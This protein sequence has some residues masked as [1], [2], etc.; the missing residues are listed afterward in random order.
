MPKLKENRMSVD[1]C[2]MVKSAS[3]SEDARKTRKEFE[4][5]I[6]S[7][8]WDNVFS[9]LDQNPDLINAPFLDDPL[10]Y[11]P[12]HHLTEENAPVEI[13]EKTIS[14]GAWRTLKTLNNEKPMD[15]ALRK[16]RQELISLL[17]PIYCHSL[18]LESLSKIQKHFHEVIIGRISGL[19]NWNS[20]RL[21]ELEVL[22]EIKD[23]NMWFAV[24]GMYGGFNYWLAYNR[25][26]T[27]RLISE[28]W[29][30][31]VG[32]SGQRHEITPKGSELVEE[33]FV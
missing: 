23:P 5:I 18:D 13:I 6:K 32:G 11:S 4:K 21:P 20:L 26:K 15:I 3:F 7:N 17:T 9:V 28:N 24:P 19:P 30:R 1:W 14:M 29:C 33:G 22:L 2:G 16:G 31:V 8:R 10:W 27:I 12:L 25:D